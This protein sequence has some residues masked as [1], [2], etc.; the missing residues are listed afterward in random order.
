V[1]ESGCGKSSLARALVGLHPV[2]GRL[3][4]DGQPPGRSWRRLAQLIFQHP[5]ASLN[6]RHRIGEIIGRS[7]I[8]RRGDVGQWLERVGLPA[9]YAT[10]FPM[11]LSGGQKQRVAIARAFAANPRLVVCD[12]ITSSLDVSVQAEILALLDRLQRENGTAMLFISHDLGVVRRIAHRMAVMYLG[13]IVEIRDMPDGRLDP[14]FHPYTEALMSAAPVATAGVVAREIRLRGV[15]PGPRAVP[16]GCRF[17]PR[18]AREMGAVCHAPPPVRQATASHA[19]ACHMP[20]EDLR[21][22]PPIWHRAP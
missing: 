20:L 5:D 7:L 19:I 2:G 21:A 9:D 22:L 4:L 10:R 15:P 8:G 13:R 16:A 14:P 3:R 6:P 12:E 17:H 11:A 1:G 18:C